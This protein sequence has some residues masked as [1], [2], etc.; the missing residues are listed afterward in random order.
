M[1]GCIRI[2]FARFYGH[3]GGCL[4]SVF[5]IFFWGSWLYNVYRN[6]ICRF[7]WKGIY[8]AEFY[9]PSSSQSSCIVAIPNQFKIQ[10][11]RMM[12]LTPIQDSSGK[13]C[14]G[15]FSFNH[16]SNFAYLRLFSL[17][18][19]VIIRSITRCWQLKYFLCSPRTLGK[20]NPF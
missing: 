13:F 6:E 8:R 12:G 16:P 11:Y 2:I 15:I 19:P 17:R 1:R 7:F 9:N 18:I 10:S 3:V 4:D 14:A 20:M 5:Y